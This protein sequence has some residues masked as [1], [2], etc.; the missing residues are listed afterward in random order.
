LFWSGAPAASSTALAATGGS[1]VA[2]FRVEGMTCAGCAATLENGLKKTRGVTAAVVSLE[3]KSAQVGY[4]P[5]QTSTGRLLD[6]IEENGFTGTLNIGEPPEWEQIT[7]NVE[8]MTCASCAVGIQ[9]TLSRRQGVKEIRVLYDAK[10]AHVVFD[11]AIVTPEQLSKAFE[12]LGYPV[13][14]KVGE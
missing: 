6:V 7:Y 10:E 5:S 9:A 1:A 8:G 11:P 3:G 14:P 12:K 4:D 2:E 13:T